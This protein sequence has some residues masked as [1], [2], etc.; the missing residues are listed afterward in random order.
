MKFV[1]YWD[2]CTEMHG[3]Q[4]VKKT[5]IYFR[6]NRKYTVWQYTKLFYVTA[7]STSQRYSEVLNIKINFW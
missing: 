4:N 2:K 6:N 5:G 3:P 7:E 1:S